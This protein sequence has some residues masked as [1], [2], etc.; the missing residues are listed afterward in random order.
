MRSN[1][2]NDRPVHFLTLCLHDLR[3]P[4]LLRLPSTV[5]CSMV[6]AAYLDGRHGQ[7]LITCD[8]WPM[9][10]KV[11]DVGE[12]INLLPYV[13]DRIMLF[14][15]YVKHPPVAFVFKTDTT[16]HLQIKISAAK[17]DNWVQEKKTFLYPQSAEFKVCF[18]F[19]NILN[20]GFYKS[21]NII[22]NCNNRILKYV[23]LSARRR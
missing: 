8:A 15:W 21:W 7:V 20:F 22:N 19:H 11:S 2:D 10:T 13:F 1:Y 23:I 18:E 5:P 14:V 3:G 6:L 17:Y 9:T 12:D 16:K 4:P